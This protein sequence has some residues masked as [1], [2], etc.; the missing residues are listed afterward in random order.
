MSWVL[1]HQVRGPSLPREALSS[2]WLCLG[3]LFAGPPA[4]V[5]GTR[6]APRVLTLPR[7]QVSERYSRWR[8]VPVREMTQQ[9][10]RH[11]GE[12]WGRGRRADS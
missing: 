10:F 3:P 11:L 4:H 2:L 7:L 6:K 12:V 8:T 9:W 1:S 5:A